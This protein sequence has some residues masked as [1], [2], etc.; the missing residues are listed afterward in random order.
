[1]K[2]V[3]SQMLYY[4]YI[5]VTSQVVRNDMTTIQQYQLTERII[6]ARKLKEIRTITQGR[7]RKLKA[8]EFPELTTV[9]SYA[10]GELEGGV[11]AHPRLTTRTVYRASD[12]TMTMRKAKEV[13]PSVAPKGFTISLSSCF[14]YTQNFR[15]GS[16]QSKQH[17][18]GKNVNADLSLKKP[19][20]TGVPQLV[21]KFAL[22]MALVL[23]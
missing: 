10:F 6:S 8:K 4:N 1:M 12:N 11:E 22:V 15:K 17:H 3:Q 16:I 9:L 18:A 7:G 2:S 23:D 13:L 19:P 14:N 20:R 5:R 21:V